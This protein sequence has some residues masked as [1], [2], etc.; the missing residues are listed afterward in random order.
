MLSRQKISHP[1]NNSLPSFGARMTAPSHFRI[2]T[3]AL[4]PLLLLSM[5]NRIETFSQTIVKRSKNTELF[6]S[7]TSFA[8]AYLKGDSYGVATLLL[9]TLLEVRKAE[10]DSRSGIVLDRLNPSNL[11]K[12]QR[13][14]DRIQEYIKLLSDMPNNTYDPTKSLLGPMYCTLYNHNPSKPNAKAPLWERISLKP[15][16]LKGQQ[17]FLNADFELS[18]INYA[19]ILG[20]AFAVRAKAT[21]APVTNKPSK[22][23]LTRGKPP[24]SSANGVADIDPSTPSALRT[25]PDVY[26]VRAIAGEIVLGDLIIPLPIEGE[27]KLIVLYADPRLRIFV[28][29]DRSDSAVGAWEQAG[30]VVVQ[31]RSDLVTGTGPIDLRRS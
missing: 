17:Y 24:M 20:K 26:N 11:G 22:G 28:S 29:A 6:S 5:T 27:A 13:Q 16:N 21:F 3:K 14:R 1:M 10:L 19:E 15:E 18:I 4:V 23:K 7:S 25:C 31:V 9:G 30:L 2:W 12:Q 8:E